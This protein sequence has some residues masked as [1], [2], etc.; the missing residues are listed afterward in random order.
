MTG[1]TAHPYGER[2]VLFDFAES[3]AVLTAYDVLRRA[4]RAD[5]VDL[6]PA[7]RSLLVLT[8]GRPRVEELRAVLAAA[9]AAGDEDRPS[10][11]VEIPVRYDGPDLDE[12]AATLGRSREDVIAT[13]AGGAY[14]SAFCGFAPGFAYLTGISADLQLPRR[15]SPRVR[16]ESGSVAVAGHYTAVYPTASPGGW[17]LLGRTDASVWDLDRDPPAVL[18]PGTRVR[19]VPVEPR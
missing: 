16:V 4:G 5:V 3:A 2:A 15:A 12:V 11:L 14:V 6:V 19:F 1:P 13:H 18:T 7:E 9:G 8:P 17:H 10:P